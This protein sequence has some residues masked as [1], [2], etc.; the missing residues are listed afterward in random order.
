MQC[1]CF[2][3]TY[4][5][6]VCIWLKSQAH[7]R[8][9]A[10]Q[11]TQC[12]CYNLMLSRCCQMID[13]KLICGQGA[14]TANDTICTAASLQ[15]VKGKPR[16]YDQWRTTGTAMATAAAIVGYLLCIGY[17]SRFVQSGTLA[18]AANTATMIPDC[19][20]YSANSITFR[21]EIVRR[22]CL[23]RA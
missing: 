19:T 14:V 3:F 6:Y 7:V 17:S 1:H 15:T 4:L 22:W 5:I 12:C 8:G 13:T 9:S 2:E 10:P 23:A 20:M 21:C 11:G 16:E 18:A